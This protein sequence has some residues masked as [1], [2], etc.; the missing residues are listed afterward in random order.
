[1]KTVRIF[2]VLTVFFSI[3]PLYADNRE[4]FIIAT[5]N[6]NL[7]KV[8]ELID[9]G[10]DVNMRYEMSGLIPG[11]PP[12]GKWT[13]LMTA[14]IRNDT[15]LAH[16]LIASDGDLNAQ[17]YSGHAPLH[18][19]A[20]RGNTA[21]AKILIDGGADV[22]IQNN[23]GETPLYWAC[24]SLQ[25]E[26]VAFLLAA[27]ADINLYEYE[28]SPLWKAAREGGR[29]I[30]DLLL[31][32][33]AVPDMAVLLAAAGHSGSTEVIRLLIDAGTDVAN[34][35][36]GEAL[37]YLIEKGDTEGF[38]ALIDA[39]AMTYGGLYRK[40]FAFARSGMIRKLLA[41]G[42]EPDSRCSELTRAAFKG[43][44][45]A[46]A[47]LIAGGEYL[48]ARDHDGRTALASACAAGHIDI[49]KFIIAAGADVNTVIRPA[50]AE[51]R[52]R[53]ETTALVLAAA[54]GDTE[55]CGILLEADADPNLPGG[56]GYTPLHAA[57]RD[58]NAAAVKLL[59]EAGADPDAVYLSMDT[60]MVYAVK[61]DSPSIVQALLEGGADPHHRIG[62]GNTYV[63]VAAKSD[64]SEVIGPLV[65]AGIDVNE[66]DYGMLFAPPESKK[67]AL[68]WINGRGYT[69]T[70]K[71]LIRY[72]AEK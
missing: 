62:T 45:A 61:R 20:K 31:Q 22:N 34:L 71:V 53:N 1:M 55:I 32:N 28:Y 8:R 50:Y 60:P 48:D 63:H 42:V 13:P 35:K 11:F 21:V 7:E 65:E 33:G 70:E 4:D 51:S 23:I 58:G 41:A 2:L 14:A 30:A 25:L 39:G 18:W 24:G 59:L 12:V 49:V 10:M 29:R 27:G 16:V 47:E 6:G 36:G 66:L 52:N 9:Q 68:Q 3:H 44:K 57:A 46:L 72:G 38:S 26:C 67:T 15:E 64:S 19:A 40:A 5:Q 69:E 54:A 37:E 43:E 56:K 17:N